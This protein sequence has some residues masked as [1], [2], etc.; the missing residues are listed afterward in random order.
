[1]HVAAKLIEIAEGEV[2]DEL[3]RNVS[4]YA[5]SQNRISEADFS[6][7]DPFHVRIEELSRTTW[8]PAV[9]GSQRQTKWFYERARG[10]YQDA[11]GSETTP[12]KRRTFSAEHP[13]RQ[14]FTKTDLAKFENTWDQLPHVVSRGAQKNFSDYMIRLSERDQTVVDP[15][16]FERLVAK[17]ILFR[18]TERIVQSQNFGGYRAN[19]V[20]Y[21]LAL[22]SN[23][24]SQRIDLD[25][26]WREQDLT[27]KLQE[28]IAEL[29]HDVHRIITNPHTARNITEWSKAERCWEIVR[30][31]VSRAPVDRIG[32]ELLNTAAT[33][34]EQKRSISSVSPDHVE[35]LKRLVKVNSEGWRM[36]VDW[37]AETESI[38]LGQRQLAL[39]I[40]RALQRGSSIRPADAARAVEILDRAKALGFAVEA[41]G[42]EST[43]N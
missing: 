35:N 3:V 41:D 43:S 22:L 20:T 23:A 37:G 6:A 7:N 17:A 16:Y 5:N 32:D 26:I 42:M 30:T 8:A 38:D 39:R 24:T 4:R 15:T 28:V 10:Q 31:S 21:T 13:T 25:Q 9:G 27:Q 12:A 2:H 11:R 33:K 34:K 14:R 1:M 36:L 40:G 29:S 19:I 18:T